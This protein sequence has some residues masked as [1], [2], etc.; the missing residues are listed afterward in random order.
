VSVHLQIGGIYCPG[1]WHDGWRAGERA[2]VD[3]DDDDDGVG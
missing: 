1:T 3:D 2:G